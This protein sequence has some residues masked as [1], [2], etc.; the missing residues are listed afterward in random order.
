MLTSPC[1]TSRNDE[2]YLLQDT[3]NEKIN[4]SYLSITQERDIHCESDSINI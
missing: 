3:I 4:Y 1:F 2:V